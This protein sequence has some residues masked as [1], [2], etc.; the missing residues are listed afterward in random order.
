MKVTAI[1]AQVKQEGRVSVFVDGTYSFSLTL[2]QLLNQKLKKGTELDKQDVVLLK[3]LS[4][5]GK[6]KQRTLEWLLLRPHSTRELRDYLYRKQV[7]KELANAWVEEFTEKKY[8]DDLSFSRWFAEGRR[9]K[10]K[11]TRAI[12]SELASKGISSVTIQSVVTELESA[13]GSKKSE[14]E[15]LSELINKLRNRSRYQDEQKLIQY[16]LS[17]GFVYAD[18]KDALTNTDT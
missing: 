9:R 12:R 10:N 14:K 18:I 3:K 1:K 11:S 17:K 4:D 6:L 2:D 16:L 8:L 15:V 5:E 7:E 13:D